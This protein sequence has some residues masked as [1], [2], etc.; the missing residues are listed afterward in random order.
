M[1]SHT[2]Y[3]AHVCQICG[4]GFSQKSSL[5]THEVTHDHKKTLTCDQ[6]GKIFQSKQAL[7]FHMKIHEGNFK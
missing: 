2:G 6:C 3:R 5:K 7:N 4:L 1:N